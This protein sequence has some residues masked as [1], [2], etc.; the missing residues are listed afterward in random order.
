MYAIGTAEI[1]FPLPTPG[2]LG[3][4]AAVFADFGTV[5]LLTDEDI[6]GANLRPFIFD[7]LTLR[8][9]VGV[10]VFW[11]SPFGPVRLDFAQVLAREDYDQTESFRFS[12]GT[13]F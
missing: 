6:G 8:A 9:S 3:L 13:R 4:D 10:S 7:D 1:G 2:D 5:G 11:D 12:G